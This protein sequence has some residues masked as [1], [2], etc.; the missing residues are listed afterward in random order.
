MANDEMIANRNM[1]TPIQRT[2]LLAILFCAA[3]SG[4]Q[5]AFLPGSNM[6]IAPPPPNIDNTIPREKHLIALPTYIIEP[7]DVLEI[8]T[9]KTIPKTPHILGTFDVV[10]ISSQG[11]ADS[12]ISGAFSID[13]GGNVELGPLYGSIRIADMN[14]DEA[15]SAINKAL[16]GELD[17][18]QVSVNLLST[19]STQQIAAAYLVQPDGY[20]NLGAYGK[21]YVTGLTLE[22]AKAAIENKLSVSLDDPQVLVD[23]LFYNS[24]TFYVI[25]EGAGF[26]DSVVRLPITGQQTVLNAISSI[27]G[28]SQFSSTKIWIARPSPVGEA[29]QILP[30]DWHAITRLGDPTTNYQIMPKDR[31]FI[32]VDKRSEMDTTIIRFTQPFNRAFGF[33]GLGARSLTAIERYGQQSNNR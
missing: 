9:I 7:P 5:S 15:T 31:V 28:I 14:I 33:L 4:C 11:D 25:T 18:P 21:V 2:V 6:P 12:R 26:G 24:K 8:T 19:P 1:T 27:Q 22:E 3:L 30:V 32:A 10:S 13:P 16:R 23:V 29:E 20:V 17:D